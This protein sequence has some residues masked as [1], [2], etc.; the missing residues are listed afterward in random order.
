MLRP[1]STMLAA[2][3]LLASAT[4]TVATAD[5]AGGNAAGK[6]APLELFEQR[7]I[8]IFKSPQPS[9]CV[10]CH[11]AAVG[12]KDYILPSHEKTFVSLRDQGLI[13]LDHPEKSKI[14]S[15]IK[16]GEKDLDKGARLIHAK[17]R[18]AEYEAF[19]AWIKACCQDPVLRKLLAPD[20]ADQAR[21]KRSDAVI[22]HARKSRV[23]D[24][25][26]RKV[27]SQRM[28]C[29]PCH[30][31]HELDETNPKHRRPIK[32]VRSFELDYGKEFA[33]RLRIF[34]ATP[35]AT[36][37]YLI[38]TSRNTPSGRLPLINL[39]NPRKSL[40][41]LKPTSRLPKKTNG[42][43][44]EPSYV[45]PVSHMGGLKMHVDDQSYKAFIAWIGDYAKVVGDQYH[46]VDELPADNWYASKHVIMVRGAPQDW[47]EFVR[48][49]F[50]V[51]GWD[52]E[53][54]A[55]QTEPIAFT[56]STV[57]PR[58]S[59]AGALFLLRPPASETAEEWEPENALAP[60]KYLIKAFVDSRRRLAD[61]PTVLLGKDDFYGLAEIEARWGKGFRE[62]EKIPGDLFK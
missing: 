58:R 62:A 34:R 61:D 8:P 21:P 1:F 13:D 17:T 27:W 12:L 43:R 53:K 33:K 31:P 14:L 55:W 38:E 44:E 26:V 4:S 5:D 25:F 54:A 48:V 47:P 15:L 35:E 57:T 30:T 39:E 9:S 51:H 3:L 49:Q 7:I 59:V 19:A 45:E 42:K 24:S 22:R 32:R 23:V 20:A 41:V 28:R 18:A 36:M 2:A 16:M 56:Q 46:S 11:L 37:Q 29:F 60:G 52:R 6:P 40:I 10:Q 50:F